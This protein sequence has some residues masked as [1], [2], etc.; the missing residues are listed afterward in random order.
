VTAGAGQETASPIAAAT[1]DVVQSIVKALRAFQIYLPNNPIYQRAIAGVRAAF[2]PLWAQTDEITLQVVETDF[3]WED[4]VV[5]HQPTK[6]ESLAWWLYKDG[7]RV[8]TLKRGAE[9][10][11][12]VSFLDIVN[13]AR[14]LPADAGDDLLTLLWEREYA[15][16]QYQFA[17]AFGDEQTPNAS[18]AA[19]VPAE[20]QRA[21]VEEEAREAP[22]PKGVVDLDDFDSTLYF[23]DEGEIQ[24]VVDEVA[25][26][27]RRDVRSSALAALYDVFEV[28]ADGAI[29]S[30]IIGIVE[31]LFPN[32]LNKN[33]FRTVAGVLRETRVL[34]E[35]STSLEAEQRSRLAQFDAQLSEPAI[36]RQLVQA[37]DEASV[38]PDDA[39]ITELLKE[40][41]P[42]AL[43]TILAALPTLGTPGV[44]QLLEQA[45]DRLA[46]THQ[47]EV[48]RLLRSPQSEALAGVVAI[49]GRLKLQGAVAGLGDTVTHADPAVRL[50]TVQ[51]LT[52]IGT[53]GAL[54]HLERAID[55][56][57]R[58]VRLAA[59]RACGARGFKAAL[60]R[61]EAV[62]A[63]K[64]VKELDLTEK[65]A[66]F[67]AYGAIAGASG[68]KQ[69]E[70]MLLGRGL[71]GFRSP[72]E[73]RAC[74]A[75]ALGKIRTAESRALLQRA[76][77]DKE[78]VV[79]NAV[80][81]ALREV[82]V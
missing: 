10:E 22:R 7:M 8:L 34:A 64:Q 80:S 73:T 31:Q 29:R 35:R 24:Y 40:L 62:V 27:Y 3:H 19:Q 23:L 50:A 78:L 65:M 68:L 32:L 36:V 67:E 56:E 41:R 71:I 74:A 2:A 46:T 53:P 15:Y 61:V 26:E 44:R 4:E 39:D 38:R 79:R 51:A 81:R 69:L 77:D 45:A 55:D 66:F 57:D 72:P 52:E 16:I 11:E 70:A 76:A 54:Q 47:A 43:E 28:Q 75:I 6:N 58:A 1:G 18:P 82:G 20:Q 37:L 12:I 5:Y 13:R 63:G 48:L 59:V 9:E 33:E 49:C 42:S 30:E 60:K 21:A 14:F 17:E 25:K